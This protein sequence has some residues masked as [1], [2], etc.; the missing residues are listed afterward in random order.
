MIIG[1]DVCDFEKVLATFLICDV[2]RSKIST[3]ILNVCCFL[4]PHELFGDG[5]R[6]N[7]HSLA[8]MGN[9]V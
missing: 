6:M 3:V 2:D 9:N 7:D 5:R 4:F 8:S 1:D